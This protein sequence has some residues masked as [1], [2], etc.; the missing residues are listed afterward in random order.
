M[1]FFMI[2]SAGKKTGLNYLANKDKEN[3]CSSDK[4]KMCVGRNDWAESEKL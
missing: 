1:C 4:T 3:A 2:F